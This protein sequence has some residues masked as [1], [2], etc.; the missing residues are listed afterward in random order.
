MS[1]APSERA[2]A[3]ALLAQ[4]GL[5]SRALAALL[6]QLNDPVA[7]VEPAV[8]VGA[9]ERRAFWFN[10]LA[11]RPCRCLGLPTGLREKSA[12]SAVKYASSRRWIVRSAYRRIGLVKWL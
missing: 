11:P 10:W 8:I 2:L 1:A 6:Q 12:F 9:S 3:W 5:P 7:V 4:K